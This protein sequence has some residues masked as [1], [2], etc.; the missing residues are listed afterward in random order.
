MTRNRKIKRIKKKGGILDSGKLPGPVIGPKAS[1]EIVD[2][3]E[4][5]DGDQE[6]FSKE[7][8]DFLVSIYGPCL[9]VD[10]KSSALSLREDLGIE[11]MEDI[12]R[13]RDITFIA[14]KIEDEFA[15]FMESCKGLHAMD[16]LL[17]IDNIEYIFDEYFG[18]Y[19][20]R[21][22]GAIDRASYDR[23]ELDIRRQKEWA[24]DLVNE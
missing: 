2:D 4:E 21:M 16:R 7:V 14:S 20:F 24:E 9:K 23:Y 10:L 5:S 11:I 17:W 12:F 6:D 8:E 3:Y 18:P 19:N 1:V 22:E 15:E 13:G